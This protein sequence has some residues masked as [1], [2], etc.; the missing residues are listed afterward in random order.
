LKRSRLR[1]VVVSIEV[2]TDQSLDVL[3]LQAQ[4]YADALHEPLNGR[5]CALRQVQLN[6]VQP[7]PLVA[8]PQPAP[9]RKA[10]GGAG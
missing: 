8:A 1:P 7:T 2:L 9:K 3:K 4:R 10:R 6:V 5:V